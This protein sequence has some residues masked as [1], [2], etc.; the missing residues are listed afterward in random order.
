MSAIEMLEDEHKLIMRVVKLLPIIQRRTEQGAKLPEVLMTVVDFFQNY[1]DKSHHAKEETVLFPLLVKRGAPPS[2]C[3]VGALH[4]EHD[5]GRLLMKALGDAVQRFAKGDAEARK[6]IAEYLK[7]ATS[8][9]TDHI[10]KEDY[11]LFPMSHKIL[12]ET[13]EQELQKQF[14]KVDAQFGQQFQTEYRY[15]VDRLEAL[16]SQSDQPVATVAPG[17]FVSQGRG[18]TYAPIHIIGRMK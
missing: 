9:Y 14:I 6:Q 12:N 4:S 13:D 3:P 7:A 18:P 2:G 8:F 17:K 16:L 11:L 10:W 5:Q 1:A 15:R